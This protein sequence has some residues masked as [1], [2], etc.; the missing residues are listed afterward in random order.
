VKLK[1]TINNTK[2]IL[3]AAVLLATCFLTGVA[4]AQSPFQGKFTLLDETRWAGAV[5][6]AGSYFITLDCGTGV[7]LAAIRNAE[8]LR[9]SCAGLRRMAPTA[10]ARYSSGAKAHNGSFTRFAY[11]NSDGHSFMTALSYANEEFVKTAARWRLFR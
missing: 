1:N 9:T 7:C 8:L 10:K 5:L 3:F 2:V 4:N 11:R 6:P